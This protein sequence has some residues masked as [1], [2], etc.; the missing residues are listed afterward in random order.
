[1][2]LVRKIAAPAL[3]A[4]IIFF[5]FI[6][7]RKSPAS[8]LWK[9]YTMLCVPVE[10]DERLVNNVLTE[11]K[12]GEYLA[13]ENQRLLNAGTLMPFDDF[14]STD[15]YIERR[16]LYF[17]DREGSSRIY[18]IPDSKKSS[19]QKAAALLQN[20]YHIDARLGSLASFPWVPA[21][22]C[23]AVFFCLF[24]GADNKSVFAGASFPAILYIACNPFYPAA[25]AV[26]FELYAFF[27]AQ[28]IWRR[29]GACDALL[30]NPYMLIFTAASLL[31]SFCAGLRCGFLYV[32]NLAAALCLL[33]ALFNL[34]L[35]AERKLRFLPLPIRSAKRMRL[36]NSRS[37]RNLLFCSGGLFILVV[38]FFSP[39]SISSFGASGGLFFPAPTEY[40]GT[41]GSFPTLE[42]F[43]VW[44]WNS[45]TMPYRSCNEIQNPVPKDGE[46]VA[47]S[48]YEK[49]PSGIKER[50]E[51][52]FTYGGDFKKEVL[53]SLNKTDYGAIE[54][55]WERQE[56]RFSV[57]YS[58]GGGQE[59]GGAGK[60]AL[61]FSLLLSLGFALYYIFIIKR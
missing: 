54:K 59:T 9:G 23:L 50:R 55:L 20:V 36:I 40:N 2:N 29:R 41:T 17:F 18:Y 49:T 44:R 10:T 7:L 8:K 31:I 45:V 26:C 24:A 57:V 46:M 52:L 22:V 39:S 38:F 51:T 11:E 53:D 16:S 3:A 6:F 34:E 43:F 61:L 21:F 12:C 33:A 15:S 35:N 60:L 28:R 47:F 58:S 30:H 5:L 13:L 48:H 37:V 14:D 42:D 27:L 56:G 4:L 32:L 25:A 19:G 1:M